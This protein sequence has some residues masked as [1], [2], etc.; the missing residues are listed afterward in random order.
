MRSLIIS[1]ILLV[2][3]GHLEAQK[4]NCSFDIGGA[5]T[6]SLSSNYKSGGSYGFNFSCGISPKGSVYFNARTSNLQSKLSDSLDIYFYE[7]NLGYKS[8]LGSSQFFLYGDGGLCIAK[9]TNSKSLA[10]MGLSLGAGYKFRISKSTYVTLSSGYN[11]VFMN[12]GNISWFNIAFS[13]GLGLKNIK[14][15]LRPSTRKAK[16]KK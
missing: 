6:Q 4:G 15:L 2:S 1:L 8:L 9:P 3:F 14:D 16:G 13:A 5:F 11:S 12:S 10:G 7:L